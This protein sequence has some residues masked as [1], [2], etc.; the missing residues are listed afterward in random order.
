MAEIQNIQL[1]NRTITAVDRR[2]DSQ[3][4][5]SQTK[6]FWDLLKGVGEPITK[7]NKISKKDQEEAV[8]KEDDYD[9]VK[10]SKQLEN[11][12]D[13]KQKDSDKSEEEQE[14][15]KLTGEEMLHLAGISLF[16]MNIEET[17][18]VQSENIINLSEIMGV[19]DQELQTVIDSTQVLEEKNR[20]MESLEEK[21]GFME[22]LEEKN[23]LM[24]SLE[25]K[26]GVEIE[27]GISGQEQNGS[28][29]EEQDVLNSQ[30]QSISTVQE[31]STELV[32]ENKGKNSKE[33]SLGDSFL[34]KVTEGDSMIQQEVSVLENKSENIFTPVTEQSKNV[35]LHTSSET[36]PTD[37]SNTILSRIPW[38][39]GN[40]SL[41]ITLEPASLGKITIKMIYEEGKAA[42]SLI[43][44]NPQTL[45]IL[46]RKAGEIA[47]ILQEKT[48]QETVIYT[49][50]TQQYSE[51]EHNRQEQRGGHQQEQQERPK[52]EQADS[53]AQQLRLGLI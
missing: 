22:S 21:N 33:D 52:R 46:S 5:D 25:E 4:K 17:Q 47:Q 36:L 28:M 32:S 14:S 18:Q 24:E 50:E 31:Q 29:I 43:S 19:T 26:V 49:P 10:E 44:N 11:K 6:D 20:L 12:E 39:E 35:F 40:A 3:T 48:G 9:V 13:V 7:T 41:E 23:G 38:K 45:E 34:E 30:G 27:D 15:V 1:G 51:P 53:F 37:L 42:L 2:K 8:K 16:S